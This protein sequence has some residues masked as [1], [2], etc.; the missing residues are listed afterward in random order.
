[1][2]GAGVALFV[3]IGFNRRRRARDL[4]RVKEDQGAAAREA[5]LPFLLGITPD[6][7][8]VKQAPVNHGAV[9][10][11]ASIKALELNA[12]AQAILRPDADA[13]GTRQRFAC[14][15]SGRNRVNPGFRAGTA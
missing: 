8:G 10:N 5:D 11:A 4:R 3:A 12:A 2:L 9:A 6:I 13:A 7:D 1:M 14:D 15:D